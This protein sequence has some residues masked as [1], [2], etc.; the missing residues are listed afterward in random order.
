MRDPCSLHYSYTSYTTGPQE[1]II[2]MK[3][4]KT[5]E[6]QEMR[7][8]K[9]H[10]KLPIKA[11]IQ[12]LKLDHLVLK[13]VRDACLYHQGPSI[14]YVMH[15]GGLGRP[16]PLCN[17]VIFWP[18]PHPIHDYVIYGRPLNGAKLFRTGGTK[19]PFRC[20]DEE[21]GWVNGRL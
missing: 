4:D 6:G 16:P 8:N 11:R 2:Y 10:P 5:K 1:S 13:Q 15:F 12:R 21:A 17:I 14:N 7:A 9:F 18:D 19:R 20:L 3:V